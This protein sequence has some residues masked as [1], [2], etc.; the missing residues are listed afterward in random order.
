MHIGP[1][2]LIWRFLDLGISPLKIDS[3]LTRDDLS[4]CPRKP[5]HTIPAKRG[6]C[7]YEYDSSL[8]NRGRYGC[9]SMTVHCLT[10][11]IT[12]HANIR[13]F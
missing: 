11:D 1:R 13:H 3:P 9:T 6:R 7:V 12:V 2:L 8:T 10:G 4:V 5:P